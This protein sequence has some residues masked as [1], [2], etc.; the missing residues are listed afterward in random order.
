MNTQEQF[1]TAAEQWL[2]EYRYTGDPQVLAQISHRVRDLLDQ[3]GGYISVAH[4]ERA[5]LGLVNE[6]AIKPFRDPLNSQSAGAPAI[7]QDVIDFIEH[8][9]AFEQRRRY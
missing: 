2:R 3:N 4:F 5:Y 7:P 1:D 6:G 8:G 9:S